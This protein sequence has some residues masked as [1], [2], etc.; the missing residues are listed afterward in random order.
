MSALTQTMQTYFHGE[1]M[2]AWLFIVPLGVLALLFSAGLLKTD[3]SP[4]IVGFTTPA[5]VLGL[6]L[7]VTGG[8]VALR[9]DSQ[10]AQLIAQMA[11]APAQFAAEESA[12]M[13][14]VNAA[15]P[16]YLATWVGFVVIG[17]LLRFALS[18]PWAHGLGIALVLFGG[19]G[20]VIDG[21]A[22]RRAKVYTESLAQ[23]AAAQSV[24]PPAQAKP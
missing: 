7:L 24:A 4:F 22:E 14:K 20:L 1:K 23:F 10:L 21:F 19:F 8:T 3:R 16:I 15:W 17:V 18:A 12:R 9:T 13:A 2:E 5:I 6:V 11:S